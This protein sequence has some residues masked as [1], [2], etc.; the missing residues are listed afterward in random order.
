MVATAFAASAEAPPA[1]DWEA[2]IT[3]YGWLTR[4]DGSVDIGER[5][6][7]VSAGIDDVLSHFGGGGMLNAGFRWRRLLVLGDVVF[8]RLTDDLTSATVQ[9][10]PPALPVEV[11]PLKT[12]VTFWEVTGALSLGY[13]VLDLPFPG[14]DVG[15][16]NDPRR[17]FVDA[18]AGARF[19]YFD[20]KYELSIPPTTVGGT[21]VPT[22]G[23]SQTVKDSQWWVDPQIGVVLAARP[24]KRWS[25]AIG[26]SVGGFGVG[27][28]SKFSWT[29]VVE[30]SWHFAERWSLVAA[31]KGLGFNRDFSSK[32]IDGKIDIAMHGPVLGVS[33][34]F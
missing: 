10:G 9:V 18:Y 16:A 4:I 1:K 11:G 25:F 30:G 17:L 8:A 28:S 5:S 6:G 24:W 2:R 15:D 14:R 27:S 34:R 20:Q 26:G 13:R 22:G 12:D 32:T 29:G 33:Y 3:P 21:P 7:D 23:R 19:W 31:Y